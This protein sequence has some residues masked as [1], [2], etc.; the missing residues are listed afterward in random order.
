[1]WKHS[2]V[3]SL[4]VLIVRR[5][6]RSH[7]SMPIQG[8]QHRFGARLVRIHLSA[9][10]KSVHS[11]S[12][13]FAGLV[14]M[15]GC[16]NPIPSRTRSLNAS[17]PMV[18]RLKTRKSRSLPGLRKTEAKTL[19]H[20]IQTCKPAD[21]KWQRVLCLS[22]DEPIKPASLVLRYASCLHSS[23]LLRGFTEIREKAM[24]PAGKKRVRRWL[25][26]FAVAVLAYGVV[27]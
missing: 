21:Q 2:N 7:L 17:A 11:L 4:L 20:E 16:P 18:L 15:A 1:M 13:S 27:A 26:I 9:D 14:A 22:L 6:D 25:V 12:L 5:L 8:G 23:I 19:H 3:W 24:P 10:M